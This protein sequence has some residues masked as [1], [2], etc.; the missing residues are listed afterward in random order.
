[1]DSQALEASP[2][3]PAD[4]QALEV[5]LEDPVDSQE[6]QEVLQVLEVLE[7]LPHNETRDP[8]SKKSIKLIR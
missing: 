6:A 1:V 7:V 3:D 5:S 2:E 8:L 4:S